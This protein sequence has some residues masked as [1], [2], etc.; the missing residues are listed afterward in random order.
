VHD[1][2]RPVVVFS[3]GG[4]GGHLYPA[5]ALADALGRIRPGVRC[6]FVGAEGGLEA[7]VL[8]E[9]GLEHL[10]LP[11]RGIHRGRRFAALGV[12]PA[13]ATSVVRVV[14][15]FRSL[16][17]E[18]V[19]VTGGYAGGPAGI[20]AGVMKI[21]LVLQ[22]QNAVP[23]ITVRTLSRWAEHV[24]LAFPEAASFL[25][26]APGPRV[27]ISGNPVRPACVLPR[28]DARQAL[29]L[30]EEGRPWPEWSRGR[31]RRRGRSISSG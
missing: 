7:R 22:E 6:F 26:V 12:A 24:H 23:G 3:G 19:V 14:G 20:A 9:R 1:P 17:P 25:P 16:S 30:P 27:W 21:P 31:S 8:P 5:L 4:T 10:L 18:V 15:L 11:V 13:L 28:R 29:G 2:S